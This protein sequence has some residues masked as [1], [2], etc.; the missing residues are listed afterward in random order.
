M[1]TPDDRSHS[2]PARP[3]GTSSARP[4]SA[5]NRAG[6]QREMRLR[7]VR[8]MNLHGSRNGRD[9]AAAGATGG[10]L[11][12]VVGRG[13]ALCGVWVLLVMIGSDAMGDVRLAEG[14]KAAA[15]IVAAEDALRWEKTAAQELKKYLDLISGAEF[16]VVSPGKAPAGAARIHVG[17]TAEARRLAGQVDWPALGTDGIVIKTA[18]RDLVLAGGRP[19][20]TIYA[21][22][23]FLQDVLSCRWWTLEAEMIPRRATLTIPDLNV[24]YRPKL[25]FRCISSQFVSQRALGMKLRLN[26]SEMSFDPSTHSI[27]KLLPGKKHFVDHPDW[28]MYRPDDGDEK[29]KYSYVKGLSYVKATRSAEMYRVAKAQRRL[30]WQPCVTSSG[31]AKAIL[32]AL[33]AQLAKEYPSWKYPPK[34]AWVTQQDGR[35]MCSCDACTALRR[36]EGSQSAGWV[37]LA[38]TIAEDIEKEYPDVLVGIFAYLHTMAPPKTVKAHKNV[39]IYMAFL[40]R[41]HKEP[42]GRL[43]SLAEHVGKWCRIASHV[44]VWDYSAN[45]RNYITP[46]PNHFTIGRSLK[47]Y[48]DQGVRGVMVQ[49]SHGH[50]SEFI[51]MRGW[52]TARMMWNADQDDRALMREFLNGYYGAAG[53]HLMKHVELLDKVIRRDGGKFLSCFSTSTEGWLALK[54]LNAATRLFDQAARAVAHDKLLSDRL[55]KARWTIDLVWLERYHA[56]KEEA[57]RQQ[58]PFLGPGDPQALLE[59]LTRQQHQVGHYKERAEFPDYLKELRKRFAAPGK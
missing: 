25:D 37:R 12:R 50:R 5:G 42:I 32:D 38:N 14:G 59:K 48:A 9:P 53:P 10:S 51:H 26:G 34:I 6:R 55:D 41:D 33:R 3:N 27:K 56:L 49:G 47:F 30:P 43:G 45:F 24:V 8:Q 36:K 52:V 29:D 1:L 16:A 57:A 19:R 4:G 46:H 18:G 58:L 7:T 28:F 22:Y 20:G 17:P 31:A 21:V 2:I 44:Y 23:T 40:D 13:A 35:W 11:G 39:L 54:D 15:V